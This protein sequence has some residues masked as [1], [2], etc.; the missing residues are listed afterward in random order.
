[1]IEPLFSHSQWNVNFLV[2]MLIVGTVL[3]LVGRGCQYILGGID[4][5]FLWHIINA[6]FR[7]F[8]V[9]GEL[10]PDRFKNFWRD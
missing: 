10:A 2:A 9:K 4:P 5:G 7:L 8:P 6:L 1:L 3:N